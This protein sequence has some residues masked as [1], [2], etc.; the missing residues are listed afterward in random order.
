MQKFPF[1][2][3]EGDTNDKNDAGGAGTLKLSFMRL[4]AYAADFTLLAAVLAGSQ[5][6]LNGLTGGF[7]FDLLQ[8]GYQIELWVLLTVSLPTWLYFVWMEKRTGRT[9]GK[10]LLRLAVENRQGGPPSLS[11]A[12]V[13]TLIRLLPWELTHLIILVPDPWWGAEQPANVALIYIPNAMLVLY[14]AYLFAHR[15]TRSIHDAVSRTRVRVLLGNSHAA[16]TKK[17][18]G[19]VPKMK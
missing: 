6:L 17:I 14:V 9:L 16:A 1:A 15:G 2:Y 18:P 19:S 4:A 12:F 3:N 5:W 13:R 7:P 8:R 11:Q 10:R